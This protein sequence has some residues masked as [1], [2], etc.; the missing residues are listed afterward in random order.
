MSLNTPDIPSLS[1]QVPAE[2][3]RAFDALK[4]WFTTLRKSGGAVTGDELAAAVEDA[5]AAT[6]ADY[7]IP[8]ALANLIANGAFRTI[9]LEWD[10]PTYSSFAHAEIWR[11]SVDNL[12]TA[13]MV[14]TTSANVYSDLPPVA[15]LSATYYYWVRAVNKSDRPGP[16]NATAGTPATT[17][18]DPAYVLDLVSKSLD[19]VGPTFSAPAFVIAAD[20]FAIRRLTDSPGAAKYPFV[21]D[22]TYGVLIDLALIRNLT[23]TNI[24]AGSISADRLNVSQLSAVSSNLGTVTAG[25]IQGNTIT[26]GTMTGT[27]ITGGVFQTNTGNAGV[28]RLSGETLVVKDQNGVTRV[29]LGYLL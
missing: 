26:G 5:L 19:A 18:N 25:T 23:A 20:D 24:M 29:K 3:R 12:G 6:G 22:A 28:T 10:M 2:V 7:A 21:V 8:P 4:G 17:A 9:M 13:E 15:S 1:S 27:T 16:F 14:G 11:N